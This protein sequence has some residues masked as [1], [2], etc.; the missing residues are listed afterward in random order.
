MKYLKYIS[1]ILLAIL[2]ACNLFDPL[3]NELDEM[4]STIRQ[5]IEYTV[6]DDDFVTIANKALYI[7]PDDTVNAKFIRDNKFFTDE[8]Q[9]SNYVPLLLNELFPGL[10]TGSQASISYKYNGDM[11]EELTAYKNAPAFTFS[12]EAYRM[13]ADEVADAGYF[14]PRFN[15]DRYIPDVLS[16]KLDTASSGAMYA[17]RYKY[18]EVDPVIDYSAF[19]INPVWEENFESETV[20]EEKQ[21]VNVSGAQKWNWKSADNGSVAI[22]GWDNDYFE[23]EDWLIFNDIDLS[24][25]S[26]AHLQMKHAVEFYAE[27][28]LF[29]QI[30]TNYDGENPAGANWIEVPFPNHDGSDKNNY[31]ES[32]VIDISRFDGKKV[33]LALKYVSTTTQAPYWGVGS[34]KIGPYGFKITGEPPYL[35]ED[36]YEYDGS[37][38]AKMDG[39]YTLKPSDYQAMGEPGENNFFTASAMAS[40]YLPE[41]AELQNPFASEGASMVY[42]YNYS[43]GDETL[44]LADMLTKKAS[45]WTSSYDYIR[46]ISE[47][48]ASTPDGW[49]FDPTIVFSMSSNDY[50]IIASYVK[51]DPVLS[52]LDNNNYDDSEYYFGASAYYGNFDTRGGKFYGDAFA[53]WEE[54]VTTAIG[55]ILLPAKYPEAVTQY[56]GIDMHYIVHFA[57]YGAPAS[58]YWVKFQCTKAGPDP[59]FTL[60]EGPV[61]VQ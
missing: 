16:E 45:G 14:S 3:E 58:S 37:D 46:L 49:V 61:P 47:P 54:A 11:P 10:G 43:T 7:N 5:E 60:V 57:T 55:T 40:D 1:I 22:E 52:E 25:V 21:L 35:A 4:D 12:D 44:K 9:A 19:E 6:T 59:E 41:F 23:N 17:V 13:V 50:L 39:V 30:S 28:C 32:D 51:N 38:W 42:L 20:V 24:T 29:V 8:V 36:F 27:G 33:A 53:T 15:P 48:Y 18:S 56:K 34:I 31:I 2:S 26:N